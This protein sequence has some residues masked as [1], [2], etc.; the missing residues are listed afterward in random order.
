MAKAK[1]TIEEVSHEVRLSEADFDRL[2][3]GHGLVIDLC[4]PRNEFHSTPQVVI[5]P[6][7]ARRTVD[8]YNILSWFSP[9]LK[10]GEETTVALDNGDELTVIMP[11]DGDDE[12]GLGELFG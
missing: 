4:D 9:R 3:S 5:H 1:A 6:S 8:M 12:P 11:G 2:K 7:Q 10:M